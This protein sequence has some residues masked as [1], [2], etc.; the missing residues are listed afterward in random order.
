MTR[1][2]GPAPVLRVEEL[3]VQFAQ[4]ERDS[5]ALPAVD[6]LSFALH[7]GE[8]LAI[9]GESGCGKSATALALMGLLPRSAQVDGSVRFAGTEILGA[10]EKQLTQIR[11]AQISMIF[12]DPLSALNP[13]LTIGLQLT[14]V[15]RKHLQLNRKD[16][17]ARAIELLEEVGIPDPQQRFGEYPHQLSGGMRQRVMIAIAIACE[18]QILIAD[19]PT[20]ALDTTIQAQILELLQRIAAERSMSVILI[21]HDLGVVA[22]MADRVLVM[23]GGRVVEA[24]SRH[25]LFRAPMH[26]YTNGLL[27]SLPRLDAAQPHRLDAIPGSAFDRQAWASAC[28]FAN[29]CSFATTACHSPDIPFE[30]LRPNHE[31]RCLHPAKGPKH[32]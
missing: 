11:G 18:P 31:V 16:A 22:G 10:N 3:R 23:Y 25:D 6:G 1:K 5:E 9:V 32:A 14:E 29:R 27:N 13:V 7:V 4:A 24:A 17:R 30:E 15:L 19:E 26:R 28:A 12:Q 21:T 20:T 2:V 8:V